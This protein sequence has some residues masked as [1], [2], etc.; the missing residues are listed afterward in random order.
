MLIQIGRYRYRAD[1]NCLTNDYIE[2]Q[3]LIDESELHR[4]HDGVVCDVHV[5]GNA[6]KVCH[7]P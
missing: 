1:S 5:G 6:R 2:N 3:V 4:A 7:C